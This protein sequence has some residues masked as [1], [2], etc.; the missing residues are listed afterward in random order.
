MGALKSLF[1]GVIVFSGI[2]I[3][4]SSFMTDTAEKYGKDI[5][6]I[7]VL[8]ETE[9][10]NEKMVNLE[11]T[12]RTKITGIFIVDI[13]LVGIKGVLE[14]VDL[15]I[16]S[17][18]GFYFTLIHS[19]AEYLFLPS[20]FVGVVLSVVMAVILLASVSAIMKWEL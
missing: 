15:M 10:I 7:S 11:N 20:W 5:D 12:F 19:I 13:A 2:I 4:I 1:I 14:F 17:L 16:T 8:G 6:D 18:F 9:Q 3:A